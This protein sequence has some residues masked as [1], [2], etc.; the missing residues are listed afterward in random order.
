MAWRPPRPR[1]AARRSP[2][3]GRAAA[4]WLSPAPS[5]TGSNRR[6]RPPWP[7]PPALN[8]AGLGVGRPRQ[9]CAPPKKPWGPR[10]GPIVR[11]RRGAR[12]VGKLQA[13]NEPLV[14]GEQRALAV[15][16][17]PVDVGV[18]VAKIERPFLQEAQGQAGVPVEV[19]VIVAGD[20]V[21]VAR[22]VIV[23]AGRGLVADQRA[24]ARRPLAPQ[25]GEFRQVLGKAALDGPH[26]AGL[27]LVVGRE[28][29]R[30]SQGAVLP[31]LGAG[32]DFELNVV[33]LGLGWIAERRQPDVGAIGI[34]VV[35]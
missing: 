6:C 10:T 14:A 3:T 28:E 32:A 31:D 2:S 5:R 22:L 9:R 4:S 19:M 21:D 18:P 27:V 33:E 8:V 1:P 11:S 15:I 30:G 29:H 24:D 13:R 26:V 17:G 7:R 34:A 35:D 12:S 23:A 25:H 20:V 16:G